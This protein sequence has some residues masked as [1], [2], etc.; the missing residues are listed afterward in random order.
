MKKYICLFVCLF[1]YACLVQAQDTIKEVDLKKQDVLLFEVSKN[2][3]KLLYRELYS[4]NNF[5]IGS[6]EWIELIGR[7]YFNRRYFLIQNEDTMNIKC[8]C[9][10]EWNLYFK[11]L[12]FKKGN[13]ELTFTYPNL[14]YSV[15]FISGSEINTPKEIQN[16][17][18]KN[19]YPWWEYGNRDFRDMYFKDLKFIKID[20]S[21]T[22]NVKLEKVE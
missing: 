21:D 17:L 6:Q 20:L 19:A 1:F 12:D 22:A 7:S 14:V 18:F 13:Y 10:Q 16:I 2:D 11:N 3:I 5:I 4:K 9:G 8:Y 15:N